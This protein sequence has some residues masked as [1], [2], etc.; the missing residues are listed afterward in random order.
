MWEC[1]HLVLH[2]DHVLFLAQICDH[3]RRVYDRMFEFRR[4]GGRDIDDLHV[5]QA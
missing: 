5:F 4:F 1:L 2:V 3:G